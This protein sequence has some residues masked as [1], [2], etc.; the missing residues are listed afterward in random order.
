MLSTPNALAASTGSGVSFAYFKTEVVG[1]TA[2]FRKEVSRLMMASVIPIAQLSLV[3]AE[4]SRNGSTA[5]VCGADAMLLLWLVCA[6][7]SYVRSAM[8][9][10]V[11]TTKAAAARITAVRFRDVRG[12]PAG[13]EAGIATLCDSVSRFTRLRSA[14]NSAADW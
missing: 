10:S 4:R 8:K 2:R 3:V 1:L 14:F 11:P 12:V 13:S 7:E 9:L 5:I 6:R